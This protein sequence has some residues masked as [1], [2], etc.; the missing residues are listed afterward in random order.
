[1]IT[2]RVILGKQ[3]TVERPQICNIHGRQ[4]TSMY[5]HNEIMKRV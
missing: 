5:I 4:V 3:Q 1:M 2:K